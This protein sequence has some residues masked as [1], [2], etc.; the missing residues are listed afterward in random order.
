MQVWDAES[1]Q[2]LQNLREYQLAAGV[3]YA[4]SP[5]SKLLAI[6]GQRSMA[7]RI[8]VCDTAT[9]QELFSF[10]Q[11]TKKITSLAFSPDSQR[12]ASGSEDKTLR[13]W[14]LK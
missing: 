14:D 1:G 4:F 7:H 9:G 13:I 8:R 2:E 3:Y 11:H 5:D 12:L 10:Q 6:S